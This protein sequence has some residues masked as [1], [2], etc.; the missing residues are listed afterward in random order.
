MATN[1]QW[2]RI[3][4]MEFDGMD[5]RARAQWADL[6]DRVSRRRVR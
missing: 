3:A 5:K 1:E 2:D 4:A 6:R